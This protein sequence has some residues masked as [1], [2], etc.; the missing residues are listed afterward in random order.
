MFNVSSENVK[1]NWVSAIDDRNVSLLTS[2]QQKMADYYTQN[3]QYFSD[4]SFN[5]DI[6]KDPSQ[7]IQVDTVKLLQQQDRILEVG[8]GRAAILKTIPSLSAKY[9]G[10]DFSPTLMRENQQQYPEASF[11]HFEQP[12]KFPFADHQFSAVFSH[13]VIEHVVFPHLFLEEC[14]RVLKPGGHLIIICPDFLG[15]NRMTSQRLGIRPGTGREKLKSGKVLDALLTG[16]DSRVRV[17]RYCEKIKSQI[18]D[19]FKFMI[20]LNPVCFTDEFMPDVD[21]VY[22]TNAKEIKNF[23]RSRLSFTMLDLELTQFCAFKKLIYLKGQKT[24]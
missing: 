24:V 18:G 15:C 3:A 21:A 17:P 10:V 11:A 20:N 14:M 9:T 7:L 13:F 12:T 5:E 22:V 16:Y 1:I 4:I 8:C 23:L 2:L 6:W 19:G